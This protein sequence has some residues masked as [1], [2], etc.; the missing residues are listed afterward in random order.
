MVVTLVP[1]LQHQAEA[2][3]RFDG[4]VSPV[5]VS[6][7]FNS[8]SV[9]AAPISGVMGGEI[10][11]RF[12]DVGVPI[13][14]WPEDPSA[15]EASTLSDITRFV[16]VLLCLVCELDE[17]PNPRGVEVTFLGGCCKNRY[18]SNWVDLG[19]FTGVHS[20]LP[21]EPGE[22]EYLSLRS[23]SVPYPL[24]ASNV[25]ADLGPTDFG[26]QL[27]SVRGLTATDDSREWD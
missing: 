13:E 23:E 19:V 11:L 21:G 18:V 1:S 20:M 27:V 4:V 2:R 5:V 26:G 9:K 12:A 14:E 25:L 8:I 10:F 16:L 17:R 6:A 22:P 24:S 15:S 3:R 7:T